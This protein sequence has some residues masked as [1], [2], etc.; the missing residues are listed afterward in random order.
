[1]VNNPIIVSAS[2]FRAYAEAVASLKDGWALMWT[3]ERRI[4]KPYYGRY[5]G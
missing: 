1:M 2:F 5:L 4:R 3:A